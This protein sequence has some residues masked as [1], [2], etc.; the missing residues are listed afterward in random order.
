[1][2]TYKSLYFANLPPLIVYFKKMFF[3]YCHT[4]KQSQ[5]YSFFLSCCYFDAVFPP[6]LLQCLFAKYIQCWVI[7]L[8]FTESSVHTLMDSGVWHK[9]KCSYHR[10]TKD[11]Q[12]FYSS[13]H[14]TKVKPKCLIYGRFHLGLMISFGASSNDELVSDS[15]RQ[16]PTDPIKST[17]SWSHTPFLEH[18]L[19]D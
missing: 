5:F 16:T 10:L 11:G 6:Q 13:F 8:V 7:V 12:C 18:Q 19:A 15:H 17:E 1:M 2:S 14:W 4:C 3:L 9:F